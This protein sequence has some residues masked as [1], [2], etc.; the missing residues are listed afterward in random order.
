MPFYRKILKI[1][2]QQFAE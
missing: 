1:A 2:A